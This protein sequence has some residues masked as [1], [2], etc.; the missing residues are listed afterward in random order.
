MAE[1]S[2]SGIMCRRR[3]LCAHTRRVHHQNT[4]PAIEQE[5]C[6]E[7]RLIAFAKQDL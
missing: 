1:L 4:V 2:L 6:H 7:T 3:A 5:E